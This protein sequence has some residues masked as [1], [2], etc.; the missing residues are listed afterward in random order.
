MVAEKKPK[1]DKRRLLRE[2]LVI[3]GIVL[4][5]FLVRFIPWLVEQPIPGY[6]PYAKYQTLVNEVEQYDYSKGSNSELEDKL[7]KST[8]SIGSDPVHFYYN[9]KAK[10][11]YYSK[12]GFCDYSIEILGEAMRFVPMIEEKMA[13]YRLYIDNYQALGDEE[14]VL[15]YEG[16]YDEMVIINGPQDD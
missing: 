5:V 2:V 16:Y 13:M 1:I 3:G 15:E 9:L 10:A 12:S 4:V 14:K 7:D 6:E 11:I 8:E